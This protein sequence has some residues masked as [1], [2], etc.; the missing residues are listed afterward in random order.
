MRGKPSQTR[1]LILGAMVVA[2]SSL[3]LAQASTEQHFAVIDVDR[4]LNDSE[5]GKKELARIKQIREAKL[6]EL[7]AMRAEIEKSREKLTSLGFSI[8]DLE[9]R[10]LQRDIE[11]SIIEGQRKEKDFE[12]EINNE[13]E[14]VMAD[15]E[16][17]V[18]PIIE[19]V[20]SE[21]GILFIFNRA[22]PGL[23]YADPNL[24]ITGEVIKRLDASGP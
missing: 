10:K 5:A 13:I 12:R 1:I 9:R 14:Q 2:V 3:A 22:T 4:V 19:K 20:G 21:R 6:A 11:D 8:S 23:V 16:T 15:L 18:I 24:D 17:K 7:E